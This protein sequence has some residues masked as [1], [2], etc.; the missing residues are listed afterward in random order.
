TGNVV[1]IGSAAN[2]LNLELGT[3]SRTFTVGT[4]DTL[5]VSSAISSAGGT[6]GITKAGAGP[7]TLSGASTYTGP[8]V[9]TG[10]VLNV[11]SDAN[12]GTP[13]GTQNTAPTLTTPG[14]LALVGTTLHVTASFTFNVNRGIV[15]G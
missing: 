6:F 7:L 13:P 4:G 1:V 15:I 3:A 14:T 2:P 11:S 12:L 9:V 10:G 5:T 8:T